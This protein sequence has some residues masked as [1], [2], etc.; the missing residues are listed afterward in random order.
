MGKRAGAADKRA[1]VAAH[2]LQYI[3]EAKPKC[4]ILENVKGLLESKGLPFFADL[5]KTLLK[6]KDTDGS[7]YYQLDWALLNTRDYGVPQ[8]RC[9]LY[10][11]G[12]AKKLEVAAFAWPRKI[13]MAPLATFLDPPETTPQFPTGPGAQKRL[14]ATMRLIQARGGNLNKDLAL[15]QDS[16]A[17]SPIA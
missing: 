3:A 11:V 2:I 8:N 5:I 1:G 15:S 17:L 7:K 4:F 16:C 12:W 10:I 9:R 14:L 6:V 13:K